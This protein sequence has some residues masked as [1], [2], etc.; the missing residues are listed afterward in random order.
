[1]KREEL[2]QERLKEL[3]HYDHETGIF[4]WK[5]R[6][7]EIFKT[8]RDC[9]AWNT[10]Y[11]NKKAGTKGECGYMIRINNKKYLSRRLAWFYT[12]SEWP[13]DELD[14]IDADVFNDAIKNLRNATRTD[15]HYKK[16]QIKYSKYMMGVKSANSLKNPYM[17]QIKIKGK[18]MHLGLFKTEQEAHEAYV[19]AKR[20][21]S[22][23]FCML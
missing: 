15:S 11:A 14:Q 21:I 12:Y 16:R 2:T 22:P 8:Q 5:E 9:N 18:T 10:R 7:V 23:E 1:M 19:K 6:S 4:T 3:L 13:E 17:S 20:Q